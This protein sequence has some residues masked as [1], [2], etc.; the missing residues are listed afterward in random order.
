MGVVGEGGGQHSEV[1]V[2]ERGCGLKRY[3][4]I[5]MRQDIGSE[6]IGRRPTISKLVKI[7]TV[8]ESYSLHMIKWC[9]M[10]KYSLC[11]QNDVLLIAH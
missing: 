1:G 3:W 4:A 7:L 8:W 2:V 11:H 5:K 9:N 10:M 6:F